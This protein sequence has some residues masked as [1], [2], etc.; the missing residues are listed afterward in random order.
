MG[1]RKKFKK[2]SR[3]AKKTFRI[4]NSIDKT[5][6]KFVP[7]NQKIDSHKISDTGTEEIKL[8]NQHR[9]TIKQ[10]VRTEA[11]LIRLRILLIKRLLEIRKKR[12]LR[13]KL[14][15]TKGKKYTIAKTEYK[16][17]RKNNS[18]NRKEKKLNKSV[19]GKYRLKS[20]TVTVNKHK[21]VISKKNS[22]KKK[23]LF[24]FSK[25]KAAG[26]SNKKPKKLRK[27]AKNVVSEAGRLSS[28]VLL[29]QRQ[30]DENSITDTGSESVKLMNSTV[31]TGKN[32]IKTAKQTIKVTK[33]TIKTIKNAPA[34]IKRVAKA[35]YKTAKATVKV[36]RA[37]VQ[38]ATK[39]ISHLVAAVSNPVVLIILLIVIVVVYII[40][41]CVTL[42]GG[43]AAG[44]AQTKRAYSE[45][46][47]LENVPEQLKQGMEMIKQCKE[48]KKKAYD[49]WI[50]NH[51]FDYNNLKDSDLIYM[52]RYDKDN[53][54]TEYR[55]GLA[56][57]EQKQVLKDALD[58]NSGIDDYEI[59]AIAY[60][61]AEKEKN[62]IDSNS[63]Y[64]I[65]KIE[66]TKELINKI[67]DDK[68][69]MYYNSYIYEWQECPDRNC[70]RKSE[71]NPEWD[72][73]YHAQDKLLNGYNEWVNDIIPKLQEYSKLPGTAQS[74]YWEYNIKWRLEN[75]SIVYEN[76]DVY[77]S[78]YPYT[79]NNG[80]DF[81]KVLYQAYSDWWDY[82]Q[83]GI[84]EYI[85]TYVCEHKHKLHSNGLEFFNKEEVMNLLGFNDVDKYWEELT[86]IYLRTVSEE[87]KEDNNDS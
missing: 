24:K 22:V 80:I 43:A 50:D 56:S 48:D 14:K 31:H 3:D 28:E 37:T 54:E 4:L 38:I 82:W 79:N 84:P 34:K 70:S 68:V 69:V 51:Y 15:K 20:R 62:E 33:N 18:L 64:R 59:L 53:N 61:L 66:Y 6:E 10:A 46:A 27:A 23:R 39:V 11:S 60:V 19:K 5:A 67:L 87:E 74:A 9:R 45:A 21:V 83:S 57:P 86:E 13:L 65:N 49:Q 16:A 47:G 30:T 44:E 75:W 77:G 8:I 29:H 2:I 25:K 26:K 35:T 32:A 36:I 78:Y 58:W 81:S 76:D 12:K 72:R 71:R 63:E 1:K 85:I 42:L 40:F 7:L 17:V 52:K 41:T 55:K 73:A